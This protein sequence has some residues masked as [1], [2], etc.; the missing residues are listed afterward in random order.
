MRA[1]GNGADAHE[2]VAGDDAVEILGK[3][4]RLDQRLAAAIGAAVEIR[5]G[6]LALVIKALHQALGGYRHLMRRAEIV[7]GELR[8]VGA[9]VC[10]ERPARVGN[11]A[12]KIRR[13]EAVA[14]MAGVADDRRIALG[15]RQR[16]VDAVVG[17]EGVDRHAGKP[18]EAGEAAHALGKDLVVPVRRKLHLEMR[19]PVGRAETRRGERAGHVA[20]FRVPPARRHV[21]G[22]GHDNAGHAL[23]IERHDRAAGQRRRGRR[24]DN[25]AG[26]K[27]AQADHG[28]E[29]DGSSFTHGFP[30]KKVLLAGAVGVHGVGRARSTC[31][32]GSARARTMER[33]A[34][35]SSIGLPPGCFV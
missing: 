19:Q 12:G 26:G 17:S 3:A 2:R 22:C 32:G 20:E 15:Q 27:R 35:P 1:V 14:G 7:V 13:R 16:V 33:G 31:R 18:A 8:L 25:H 6:D 30:P 10:L 23:P 29:R 21:D 28:L 11:D 34:G 9:S 24:G 4:R 5:L